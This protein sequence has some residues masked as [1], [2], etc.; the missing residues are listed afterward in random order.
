ML[1]LRQAYSEGI[2]NIRNWR[3]RYTPQEYPHKVVINIM[4]RAYGMNY[5]WNDYKNG[6]LPRYSNFQEAVIDMEQRYSRVAIEKVGDNLMVWLDNKPNE[7]IGNLTFSNYDRL[8][9]VA[10]NDKTKKEELE[11]SYIFDLLQEKCVLYWIAL[12]QTGKNDIDAIAAITGVIIESIPNMDYAG[13]KY[14]FQE[15]CVKQYI[16]QNYSQLP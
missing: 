16:S 3:T 5:I 7:A 12:R 8:A 4:Y 10:E 15:L 2:Q 1:D 9:T 13:A 6:N 14:V 11:F